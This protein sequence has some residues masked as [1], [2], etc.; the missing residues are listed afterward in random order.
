MDGP[1]RI[2]RQVGNSFKVELP[3]TIKIYSVFLPDRLRR[4][5]ED[6]LLGQR[7][8]PLLLIQV[9]EDKE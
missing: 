3:S 6:L 5:A 8:D 9:I 7:N 2:L 4:A 1:Y